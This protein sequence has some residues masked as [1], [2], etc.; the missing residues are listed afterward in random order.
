MKRPLLLVLSTVCCAFLSGC[1]GQQELGQMSIVI[2][3]GLDLAQDGQTSVSAFVVNPTL[4][5]SGQGGGP[6]TPGPGYVTH[7]ATGASLQEA[8]SKYLI[9]PYREFDFSHN[10]VTVFGEDYARHGVA[11]AFDFV[12]R[13]PE[14]RK[15]Q[16]LLVMVGHASSLK[17]ANAGV[18]KLTPRG[19]QELIRH[20]NLSGLAY[21]SSELNAVNQVLS[22]SHAFVLPLIKLEGSEIELAGSAVFDHNKMVKELDLMQ[23]RGVLWWLNQSA[24]TVLPISSRGFPKEG[25]VRIRDTTT[26]VHPVITH[27]HLTMF[28]TMRGNAALES[29]HPGVRVNS[30]YLE[31]TSKSCNQEIQKEMDAALAESQQARVDALQIGTRLYRQ[32]PRS[33]QNAQSHWQDLLAH[34][35]A[36]YDIQVQV[37]RTGLAQNSPFSVDSSK[38]VPHPS[39]SGGTSQ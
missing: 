23:S 34:A 37:I 18:E 7:T 39:E 13:L 31:D 6:S 29:V 35:S 14:T 16:L 22:P 4:M 36:S 10:A 5:R 15:D 33:W 38:Q 17:E 28:V 26:T 3:T 2:G 19:L 11:D 12:E 24:G 21:D 27:G 30:R 25:T 8:L 32:H 9:T 20:S 1:W